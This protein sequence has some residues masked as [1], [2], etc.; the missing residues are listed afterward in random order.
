[1]T[2]LILL[3]LS[4]PLT[5]QNARETLRESTYYEHTE[6]NRRPAETPHVPLWILIFFEGKETEDVEIY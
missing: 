3:A 5:M 6:L 1:M 4:Q 2:I